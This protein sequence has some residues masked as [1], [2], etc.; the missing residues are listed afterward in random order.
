MPVFSIITAKGDTT[1]LLPRYDALMERLPKEVDVAPLAHCCIPVA[2][3]FRVF[4]IWAD[5]DTFRRFATSPEFA[6]L[7]LEMNS[8][9][10]PLWTADGQGPFL[11]EVGARMR[12]REG[13]GRQALVAAD[14]VAFRH[15]IPVADRCLRAAVAS[16]RT[17]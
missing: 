10:S 13:H 16:L 14:A 17:G 6:A 7:R 9:I 11:D 5:E 12:D 2:E 3:G 4:D 8:R 1:E 15:A